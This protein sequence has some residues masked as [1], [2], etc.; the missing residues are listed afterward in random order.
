MKRTL[1]RNQT[2]MVEA[3][4]LCM[5]KMQL[6]QDLLND[7]INHIYNKNIYMYI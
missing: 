3:A 2:T 6:P 5:M 4:Y 7:L 1:A